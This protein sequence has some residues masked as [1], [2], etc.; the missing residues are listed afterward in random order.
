M[1]V[2]ESRIFLLSGFHLLDFVAQTRLKLHRY[3]DVGSPSLDNREM[4][5]LK[6]RIVI[7]LIVGV[8]Q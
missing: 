1:G 5:F 4:L 2:A 8:D 7:L 3:S 6:K